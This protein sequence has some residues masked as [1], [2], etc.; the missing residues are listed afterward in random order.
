MSSELVEAPE[1][2]QTGD[3]KGLAETR[4]YK[5]ETRATSRSRNQAVVGGR[6]DVR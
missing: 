4:D 1:V 5:L 3:S 6:S 2:A